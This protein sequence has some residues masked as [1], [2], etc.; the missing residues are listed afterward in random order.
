M[1]DLY[2]IR[3]RASD[4]SNNWPGW[5]QTDRRMLLTLYDALA[6]EHRQYVEWAEPQVI[7]AGQDEQRIRALEAALL[8]YGQH[9]FWKCDS[10]KILTDANDTILETRLPCT[11]GFTSVRATLETKGE[12]NGG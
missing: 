5:A 11:C 8:K 12:S 6:A 7:T 4:E 2:A 9:N 10:V 3:K 1:D